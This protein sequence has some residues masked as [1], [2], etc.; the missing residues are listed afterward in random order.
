MGREAREGKNKLALRNYY[1]PDTS[2]ILSN[3]SEYH[4]IGITDLILQ[5]RKLRQQAIFQND[6]RP[7]VK[8]TTLYS[9]P[10]VNRKKKKEPVSSYSRKNKNLK[11]IKKRKINLKLLL[12]CF[13]M[14]SN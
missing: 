6:K 11:K 3:L 10:K 13:S 7:F 12:K 14:L 8:T 4:E 2:N 1:V 5:A 9:Y